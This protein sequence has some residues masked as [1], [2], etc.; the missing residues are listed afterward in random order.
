[1]RTIKVAG[2][3]PSMNN[4]GMVLADYDLDSGELS[5][6]QLLLSSPDTVEGKQVRQN[7]KD[8]TKA[9]QHWNAVNRF[10]PKDT[11]VFVEV[12][13]GS[14]TARAMA[15][16]GICVGIL[17]CLPHTLIQVTPLEVKVAATGSKT[18]TKAEMIDWA[19]NKFNS[20][21]WL[22]KKRNGVLSY[23]ND[24]E[25]LAD[26]LAAIYA[27]LNTTEFSLLKTAIA[28]TD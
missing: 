15:S 8:I 25:H 2:L 7:S 19:T 3:D 12:P 11:I 27:G 22:T 13:V 1:M 24:N 28:K 14:Q 16:Y 5:N 4:F 18:A 6:V 10:I 26:A 9:K 23:T 17:S 20:A 21:N